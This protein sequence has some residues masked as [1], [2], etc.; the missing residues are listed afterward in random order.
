MLNDKDVQGVYESY[1]SALQKIKNVTHRVTPRQP[2]DHHEAETLVDRM[3][4]DGG[5]EDP[6]SRLKTQVILILQRTTTKHHYP[7]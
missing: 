6:E 3:Q 2:D 7:K 1:I 5:D 4:G